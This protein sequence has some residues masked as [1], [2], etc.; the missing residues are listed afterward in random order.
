MQLQPDG[1]GVWTNP[2]WV[3]GT[4]GTFAVVIGVTRYPYLEN[5]DAPNRPAENYGLGQLTASAL[6]AARFFD[7]LRDQYQVAGAP[8]AR[9]W[10][11]LAS[12]QAEAQAYGGQLPAAA[13]ATLGACRAAIEAWFATVAQLPAGEGRKSRTIFFFS[14]HGV[15]M[16]PQRQLLLTSDYLQPSADAATQVLSTYNI[17]LGMAALA[18]NHQFFFIDACRNDVARLRATRGLTVLKEPPPSRMNRDL[19]GPIFYA[20]GSGS[21]TW[22]P[23][24]PAN[25]VSFFGQAVLEA[26]QAKAAFQPDCDP[27]QCRVLSQ[28]LASFVRERVRKLIPARGADANVSMGGWGWLLDGVITELPPGQQV[29]PGGP[30]GVPEALN[31]VHLGVADWQDD[32]GKAYQVLQSEFAS[33]LI[34][35]ARAVP[36]GRDGEGAPTK[37][38]IHSI[39]RTGDK[40]LYRL[41]LT[42]PAGAYWLQFAAPVPNAD[43]SYACVLPG[44]AN[45]VPRYQ[46]EW[47]REVRDGVAYLTRLEARL[48]QPNEGPLAD[49]A[50]LWER[51]EAIDLEGALNST[52]LSALEQHL[53][54]KLDSPLAAVVAGIVLLRVRQYKRLHDWLEHLTEY[55]PTIPDG[56]VLY[57]EQLLQTRPDAADSREFLELIL[58][59]EKRGLP[60]TGE[61]LGYADRHVESLLRTT[62]PT[63]AERARLEILQ[64]RLDKALQYFRS[65]GLFAV[66]VGDSTA[67]TAA[68]ITP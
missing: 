57:A 48:A 25:G 31:P 1:P 49:V 41:D 8:L 64:K 46:L 55:F 12:T 2:D 50:A 51:Y 34:V 33:K 24:A 36:L 54:E 17:S 37:P 9:C 22:S 15:E 45:R 11:L 29:Q 27:R 65:G 26:L 68:L 3:P 6:T 30:Q 63:P 66:F 28:E 52:H 62:A 44:D 60:Y 40:D 42:V 56:P 38:V 61:A 47:R 20:A 58:Q 7:W 4:A 35:S 39:D 32:L 5:G 18:A 43:Y 23:V 19:V 13:E 53:R 16:Y 14:G 10:L 67:V 21:L 59:L